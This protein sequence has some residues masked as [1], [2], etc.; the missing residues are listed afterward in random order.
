[1]GERKAY[2]TDL[3][4]PEWAVIKP[5]IAA[6]KAAHPSVS[7]HQGRYEIR[8]IVNALR[9]QNRTGCQWELLPHDLPPTGAVRYYF[10]V[11]KSDGLDARINDVLRMMVREKAA[12]SADPSLVVLDS[13]SV[14]AGAGVPKSTTGLDAAKKT[15]GR[16]RGLAVD[17]IGLT[18]STAGHGRDRP[19]DGARPRPRTTAGPGA[20]GRRGLPAD[21]GCVRARTATATRPRP[22][23]RSGPACDA[24]ARRRHPCEAQAPGQPR[25]PQRGRTRTVHTAPLP[26]PGCL[27]RPATL[28]N[29]GREV[30]YPALPSPHRRSSPTT[31]PWNT[32]PVG[33]KPSPR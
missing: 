2:K 1:M 23:P 14:R 27:R 10:G 20:A 30:S 32:S 24:Q 9:Y 22:V 5:L 25:V 13:Q 17:V 19:R 12:R 33:R 26:G 4:E 16:L 6:W 18:R 29:P 7:G 15:P 28:S 21:H 3:T 8:E 11:W 31:S